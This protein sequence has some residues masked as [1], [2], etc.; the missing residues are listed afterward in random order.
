MAGQAK[1]SATIPTLDIR[2]AKPRHNCNYLQLQ[3]YECLCAGRAPGR[4]LSCYT[5]RYGAEH[6]PSPQFSTI[7]TAGARAAEHTTYEKSSLR[8]IAAAFTV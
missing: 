2:L 1:R 6:A 7:G 3:Y 5:A 4:R 8:T